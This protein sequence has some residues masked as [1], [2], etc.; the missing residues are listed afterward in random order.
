[1][2]QSDCPAGRLFDALRGTASRDAGQMGWNAQ[3]GHGALDL[4]AAAAHL[5]A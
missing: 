5:G 1:M 4:D 2:K 3:T